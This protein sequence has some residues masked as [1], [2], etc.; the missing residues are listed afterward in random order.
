MCVFLFYFA[1]CIVYGQSIAIFFPV[2]VVQFIVCLYTDSCLSELFSVVESVTDGD[3]VPS[4]AGI[5]PQDQRSNLPVVRKKERDY[6]GMFEYR[7][8]DEHNI[9]RHLIH[10]MSFVCLLYRKLIVAGMLHNE[11]YF[12]IDVNMSVISSDYCAR[13]TKYHIY[14]CLIQH[15]FL[16]YHLK[17]GGRGEV[18]ITHGVNACSV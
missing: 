14:L 9:V 5:L 7:K 16:I 17:S 11:H 10:G 13:R 18:V 8:E 2:F 15:F 4:P 6:M 1:V 12:A 3:A